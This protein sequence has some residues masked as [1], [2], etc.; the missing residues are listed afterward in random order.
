[1]MPIRIFIGLALMAINSQAAFA[2][3]G[4]TVL[5]HR[6][7]SIRSMSRQ[8]FLCAADWAILTVHFS[9]CSI[10]LGCVT[11]IYNARE[12]MMSAQL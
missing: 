7:R 4:N 1:M 6:M 12:P 8:R 9:E 2:A 5:L 11:M 3:D 10:M